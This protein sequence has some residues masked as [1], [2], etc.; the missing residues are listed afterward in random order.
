[1][2]W[3]A[4]LSDKEGYGGIRP[5]IAAP[6]FDMTVLQQV[7]G[8]RADRAASKVLKTE[9]ATPKKAGSTGLQ[10]PASLTNR[11]KK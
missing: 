7:L 2:C 6:A 10:W 9:L 11:R 1:M 4:R 8:H 5:P 3:Q